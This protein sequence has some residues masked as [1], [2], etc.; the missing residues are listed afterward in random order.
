MPHAVVVELAAEVELGQVVAQ[1][2]HALVEEVEAGA[3]LNDEVELLST[4]HLLSYLVLRQFLYSEQVV[5]MTEQRRARQQGQAVVDL[6]DSRSGTGRNRH[7][8]RRSFVA[9]QEAKAAGLEAGRWIVVSWLGAEEEAAALLW[10]LVC[11]G[12]GG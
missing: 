5:V 2:P 3:L 10:A 8:G 7:P 12:S 9:I 6:G 1:E 4:S 11:G